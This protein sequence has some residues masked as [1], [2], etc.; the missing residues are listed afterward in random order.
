[1]PEEERRWVR[2]WEGSYR[3]FRSSN[4]VKLELYR[5]PADMARIRAVLLSCTS[6]TP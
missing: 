1:M 6:N 5:S 3:W 2:D 4:V